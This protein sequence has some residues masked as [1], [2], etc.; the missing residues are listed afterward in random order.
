MRSLLSLL[1]LLDLSLQTEPAQECVC[2]HTA[3]DGTGPQLVQAVNGV[4]PT[5]SFA[6]T[7]ELDD[8]RLL[9]LACR[10][11]YNSLPNREYLDNCLC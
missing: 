4:C 9:L 5:E 2:T 11:D 1:L 6:I 3:S 8:I 10:D 7:N